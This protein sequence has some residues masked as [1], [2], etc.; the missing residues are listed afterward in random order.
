MKKILVMLGPNLNMVGTREK[1]IYGEENADTINQDIKSFAENA[2]FECDIFQSNHEGDLI[3]K[4]HS[5]LGVYDGVVLNAG[6]LTHYS[7]ALRDAIAS[8]TAVPFIEVHMSNVHKREEFR[9]KSVISAV[10][11]GV[12]CGFGKDSYRLGI[13]ALKGLI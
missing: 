12:I 11:A 1:N 5:T 4:I 6:A 2:G 10:C 7:Y 9:H 13:E 3:D 8:V